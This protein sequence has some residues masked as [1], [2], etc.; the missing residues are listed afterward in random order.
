M[1]DRADDD[2]PKDS[3][4]RAFCRRLSPVTALRLLLRT[5]PLLAVL[6][7]V[8]FLIARRGHYFP[9]QSLVFDPPRTEY[10]GFPPPEQKKPVPVLVL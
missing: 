1:T 7:A 9:G 8:A 2:E 10:L 3:A 5:L 6:L 4:I